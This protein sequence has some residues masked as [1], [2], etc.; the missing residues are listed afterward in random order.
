[1][2]LQNFESAVGL[3]I[4]I[5]IICCAA[6]PFNAQLSRPHNNAAYIIG[7]EGV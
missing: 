1:L 2:R 7:A 4:Y 6:Q 5:Y 3:Y